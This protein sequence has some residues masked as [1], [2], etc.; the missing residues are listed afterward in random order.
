M[1]FFLEGETHR[2]QR[3]AVSHDVSLAPL[4]Q[5]ASFHYHSHMAQ[6]HHTLQPQMP[7]C[8]CEFMSNPSNVAITFQIS[9]TQ[10]IESSS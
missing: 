6:P 8:L 1:Q 9:G 5:N 2:K 4:Q 7:T 10:L 3:I